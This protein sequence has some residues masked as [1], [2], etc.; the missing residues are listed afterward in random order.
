MRDRA[1]L[2]AAAVAAV[3][4]VVVYANS[5]GNGLVHD[6]TNAIERNEAV[7]SLTDWRTILLTPSW[8]LRGDPTT[9]SYRPLTTWTF[10]VDYALHGTSAFGYHLGNVL[11]HAGVAALVVALGAAFG[12]SPLAA[13]LAGVLFA[14]HPIH[15]EVVATGVG[16]ADILATGLALVALLLQR[17]AAAA[18]WPWRAT[19]G[20]AVAF[21]AALLAKESAIALVA[22]LPLADLM[23]ADGGSIVTFVRRLASRRGVFYLAVAGVAGAY[24]A[25]RSAA[26]GGVVGAGGAGF[27]AIVP[28]ANPAAAAP[29][30]V[31]VLTAL[32]VQALAAKL[33]VWPWHLSA[34]YSYDHLP[35]AASLEDAG[36]RT[37]V[38]VAAALVA[39]WLT[40]WRMRPIA[41]F[42][43]GFALSSY[44]VVSNIPFPIG[45]IFGE[46][47]LYL[48]SVGFCLLAATVLASPRGGMATTVV[49]LGVVAV[50]AVWSV[51]TVRRNR[52][53]H[54]DLS[55]ATDMVATAPDS[56]H[57]HHLLGGAYMAQGRNDDAIVEFGRA[58]EIFPAHTTTLYDLGL[59]QQ[60]AEKPDEAL[61]IFRRVL[62]I[63]KQ[64]FPAWVGVSAVNYGRGS[65]A[66]ALS[67]A[68][69]AIELRPD[70][71]AGHFARANALR[72]LG[73]HAEARDEYVLALRGDPRWLE[74]LFGLAASSL[75]LQDFAGAADAFQRMVDIVPSRESYRGLVYSSRRAG[76]AAEAARAADEGRTRYPDEPLFAP[77]DATP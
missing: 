38:I 42:W 49:V 9:I 22:I 5:L 20:A 17:R 51:A 41:A 77:A 56:V 46:R 59:I 74:A 11:A 28:W 7:R 40:L 32:R 21:G 60:R 71:P 72:G 70:V 23:Y 33:L 24:F 67:A 36:A 39:G 6:D 64:Y 29:T 12:L 3:L 43:L 1:F 13:G 53:W 26:L 35:I 37:G 65:F 27:A 45:T 14:A 58:L 66:P 63:D 62:D 73:R 15:T 2:V 61:A 30:R 47:L 4:S 25:L 50:T 34:D 18:G 16:R 69:R 10:A 52:V 76:R 54:D 57:A 8:K 31:R 48:P 75:D 55:L 68:E 19:V 44:L